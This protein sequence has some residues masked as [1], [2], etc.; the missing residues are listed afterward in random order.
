LDGRIIRAWG[1][2]DNLSRMQ[3]LGYFQDL[4]VTGTAMS[5]SAAWGRRSGL[6]VSDQDNRGSV[7]RGEHRVLKCFSRAAAR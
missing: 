6:A 3:Q 1:A 5:T 4:R 2:E 7:K